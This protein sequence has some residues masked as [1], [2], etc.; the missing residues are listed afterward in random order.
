MKLC[1]VENSELAGLLAFV[2]WTEL[3]SLVLLTGF[4][5]VLQFG[6]LTGFCGLV[7]SG[8]ANRFFGRVVQV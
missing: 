4:D 8:Y 6:L 5:C 3:G 2:V 7:S 1:L